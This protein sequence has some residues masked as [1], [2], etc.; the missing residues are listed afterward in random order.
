MIFLRSSGDS[1]CAAFVL[2]TNRAEPQ[3]RWKP[4]GDLSLSVKAL[5]PKLSRNPLL[6]ANGWACDFNKR[7]IFVFLAPL[8]TLNVVLARIVES[9]SLHSRDCNEEEE[10]VIT[11]SAGHLQRV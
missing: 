3:W 10:S 8:L 2:I 4:R 5:L 1:L 7:S 9:L 6:S 11:D